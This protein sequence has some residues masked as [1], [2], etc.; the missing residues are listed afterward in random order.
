MI[1]PRRNR[2]TAAIRSMVRETEV[3]VNDLIYPL[4]VV[5]GEGV[6][7]EINSW[8]GQKRWSMDLLLG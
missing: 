1:R 4:F 6:A 5:D 7:E 3:T 8:P 2:R